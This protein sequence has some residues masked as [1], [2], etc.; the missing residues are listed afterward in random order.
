MSDQGKPPAPK[1]ND[2]K[3]EKLFQEFV[4]SLSDEDRQLVEGSVQG[5]AG[6][7]SDDGQTRLVTRSFSFLFQ[8]PLPP[9]GLLKGYAEVNPEMPGE[10]IKQARHEQK[11]R[12]RCNRDN[13][14]INI[15]R[16]NSSTLVLVVL[17]AVAGI[18][19]WNGNPWLG[20]S[21]SLVV[22]LPR[23]GKWVVPLF[24]R[25]DNAPDNENSQNNQKN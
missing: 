2:R 15:K 6:P 25:K 22:A 3:I 18:I 21:L 17:L 1:P 19:A 20:G 5:Y 9:P 13:H 14:E 23:F 8:G 11:E 7:F 10:I 16:I 24:R 4:D 12:S